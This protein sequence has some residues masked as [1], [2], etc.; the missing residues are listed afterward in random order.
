MKG[1]FL[2]REICSLKLLIAH[3]TEI[4]YAKMSVNWVNQLPMALC[5]KLDHLIFT[6][7]LKNVAFMCMYF[8]AAF[9]VQWR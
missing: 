2:V 5:W 9:Q 1:G 6:D 4:F 7:A 3:F 8:W